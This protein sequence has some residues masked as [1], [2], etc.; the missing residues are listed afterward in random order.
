MKRIAPQQP[1]KPTT[2]RALQHEFAEARR[3]FPTNENLVNNLVEFSDEL[4]A[5]SKDYDAKNL[6]GERTGIAAVGF[7]A[8][9]LQCAVLALRIA[10]EGDAKLSYG[11]SFD[12]LD[13]EGISR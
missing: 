2:V 12:K 6:L 9:A 3:H 11:D 10:E 1:L 7:Y 13:I 8:K 5:L 4:Q